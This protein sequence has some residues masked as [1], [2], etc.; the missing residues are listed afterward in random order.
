MADTPSTPTRLLAVFGDTW[1][2]DGDHHAPLT[3]GAELASGQVIH[4]G[5]HG[6][7]LVQL[8]SGHEL[9]LGPDQSLTLDADVLADAAADTS[10][11]TLAATADPTL[12]ADWLTPSTP[13]L[14]LDSLLAAA[15]D[16]LD[17]LLGSSPPPAEE[18]H[19]SGQE[20]LAAGMTDDSL[21]SLLRSLYG[22][23]HGNG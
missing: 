9:G 8:A 13:P 3:I 20:L 23:D 16:P 21:N 4:T 22:P 15:S 5:T 12:L 19:S 11:W 2:Q 1:L 10:E 17:Q 6:T 18:P 14:N 7:A